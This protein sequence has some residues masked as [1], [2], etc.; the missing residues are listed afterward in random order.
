MSL[1]LS[2]SLFLSSLFAS[3]F[4]LFSSLS[5]FSSSF[6]FPLSFSL[7]LSVF[8]LRKIRIFIYL[9]TNYSINY[10]FSTWRY[11]TTCHYYKLITDYILFIIIHALSPLKAS[12]LLHCCHDHHR[13]VTIE[14]KF[15][16][17][18][19]SYCH[20]IYYILLSPIFANGGGDSADKLDDYRCNTF[21]GINRRLEMK[22]MRE[23][24]SIRKFT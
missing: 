10:C 5:L 1:S 12:L 24:S 8:L 23:S 4:P 18:P 22:W 17:P 2:L 3:L 13:R 19:S 11:S 20:T 6:S 14:N 15:K 16:E 9:Y 21:I 7:F